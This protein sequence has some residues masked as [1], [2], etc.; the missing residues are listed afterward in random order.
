MRFYRFLKALNLI[1]SVIVAVLGTYILMRPFLPDIILAM[2]ANEF[3][4]YAYQS[5]H[6]KTQLGATAAQLPPIPTENRLVIPKIYVNAAINEGLDD[7][8]LDR[9]LWRRPTTSKPDLGSNTVITAHRYMFTSGANTFYHLDK[10][11]TDDEI[12]VYWQGQEYVYKVYEIIEVLPEEVEV[13]SNTKDSIITLYTC[14]PLWTT[15]KRLVVK[16]SLQ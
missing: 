13:E 5:P 10:L 9:G 3:A 4:G 11:K 14:T 16:A 2:S 15:E 8:T 1:T 7:S 12:L 6:T